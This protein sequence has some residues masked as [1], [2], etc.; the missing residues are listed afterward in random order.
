MPVLQCDLYENSHSHVMNCDELPS[1][2]KLKWCLDNPLVL[3]LSSVWVSGP[4]NITKPCVCK[5]LR[6]HFLLFPMW[7][8]LL[9]VFY[10]LD[11]STMWPVCSDYRLYIYRLNNKFIYWTLHLWQMDQLTKPGLQSMGLWV[12]VSPVRYNISLMSSNVDIKNNLLA[13][14][15]AQ[16]SQS[17]FEKDILSTLLKF[18]SSVKTTTFVTQVSHNSFT[19]PLITLRKTSVRHWFYML[20]VKFS[21]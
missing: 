19:Q 10:A 2:Q 18:Y 15:A 20:C 11:P 17:R 16:K 9:K 8:C 6:S 13:P 12:L 5:S 14:P 1:V 4:V 3:V 7:N 21:S